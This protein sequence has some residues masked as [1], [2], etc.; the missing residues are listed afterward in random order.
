M[1]YVSELFR[2]RPMDPAATQRPGSGTDRGVRIRFV[3]TFRYPKVIVAIC[4]NTGVL[5]DEAAPLWS[6]RP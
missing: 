2:K 1:K 6:L 4:F 3:A 5:Y